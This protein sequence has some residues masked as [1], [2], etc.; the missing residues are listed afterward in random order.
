[1][2]PEG[3]ATTTMSA[4]LIV[5]LVGVVPAVLMAFFAFRGAKR[6]AVAAQQPG[7]ASALAGGL[8]ADV[9]GSTCV[10]SGATQARWARSWP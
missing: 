6:A 4:Q 2:C 8:N 1:M 7:G 3:E 9:A 5:G 10:G